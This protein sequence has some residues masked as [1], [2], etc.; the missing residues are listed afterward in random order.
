[1]YTTCPLCIAGG[2]KLWLTTRSIYWIKSPKE[3]WSVIKLLQKL[4]LKNWF[5]WNQES[6]CVYNFAVIMWWPYI[7]LKI[8]FV[9][10]TTI[11]VK[12]V[13]PSSSLLFNNGVH[14]MAYIIHF[15][16]F[17]WW[18]LCQNKNMLFL[19]LKTG[20]VP[21]KSETWSAFLWLKP[22]SFFVVKACKL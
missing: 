13:V 10:T 5:N 17:T 9:Y 18:N 14:L 7:L 19:F 3:M 22:T 1:M 11:V 4:L 12:N 16:E 15:S 21:S 8:K 2:N 20:S 6:V